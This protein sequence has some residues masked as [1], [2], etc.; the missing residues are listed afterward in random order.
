MT[1]STHGR[2][3]N[4][5]AFQRYLE[6]F[7]DDGVFRTQE[8]IADACG[9]DHSRFAKV[10][11]NPRRMLTVEQCLR[12]A[13][14]IKE[15][16]MVVLKRAGR[17]PAAQALAAVWPRKQNLTTTTRSERELIHKWRQ[18]TLKDRHHVNAIINVCAALAV[19]MDGR[20][21]TTR[22]ATR[23]ISKKRRRA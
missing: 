16:P 22:G 3:R 14:T 10:L 6:S 11:K 4:A 20:G 1:T 5:R 9:L 15:D 7:I 12:L 2:D 19:S 18:M 17:E 8:D 13:F 23:N 21:S